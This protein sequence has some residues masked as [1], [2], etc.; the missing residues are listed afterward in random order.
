MAA[1][2]E[3]DR[4]AD[5][6]ASGYTEARMIPNMGPGKDRLVISLADGQVVLGPDGSVLADSRESV[7]A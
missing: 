4:V 3:Q 6:I 7:R 2:H 1:T 5:R